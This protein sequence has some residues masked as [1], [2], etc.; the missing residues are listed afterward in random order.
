MCGGGSI[1]LEGSQL[2]I[3]AY[4]LGAEIDPK[5]I[6]RCRNNMMDI[7]TLHNLKSGMGCILYRFSLFGR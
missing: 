5:G 3:G 2:N 7:T 4:F 1:P 6:E